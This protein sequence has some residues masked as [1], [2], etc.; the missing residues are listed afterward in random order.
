[1]RLCRF[2][3]DV[4]AFLAQSPQNSVVL[5]C[6]DGFRRCCI[7]ATALLLQ[8]GASLQSVPEDEL[9]I[10]ALK[11]YYLKRGHPQAKDQL[12]TPSQIRFIKFFSDCLS[13]GIVTPSVRS[14]SHVFS[15]A[16]F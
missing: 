12:L 9:H 5:R 4:V 13:A 14:P 6:S 1:M 11:F 3:A 15:P 10:T 8:L 7:M 2:V 16:S